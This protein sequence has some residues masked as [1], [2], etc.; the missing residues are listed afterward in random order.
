MQDIDL[1]LLPTLH[2][3]LTEQNVTR[4][5]ERVHLSV[6]ATSRALDRARRLFGDE[7]LVRRGRGV[8]RTPRADTLLPM[9][10]DAM[11]VLDALLAREP[12]FD[13][14][15]LRR[16]FVVRGNEAVIAALGGGIVE[17]VRAEAPHVHIRFE[18]ETVD[19]IEAVAAGAADLA[20][21]S[22]SDIPTEMTI[23][24][25]GAESIVGVI[26][27]DHP[28]V[29]RAPTIKAFAAL[30]HIVVSRRGRARGP[31]DVELESAGFGRTV[32]AVVP[33]Y[34]AAI[35]MVATSDAVTAAPSHFAAALCRG[36]GL[37]TF[38]L[39]VEV[40]AV[41]INQIWHGRFD[42]D[43]AHRWLRSCVARAA[44]TIS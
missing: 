25:L 12:H 3:L 17:F 41:R 40:P 35:A 13:A 7:L 24:H 9:L 20:V 44:E 10:A 19:D 37:R 26:R 4:A 11:L 27:E 6:P 42:G 18:N 5:A 29:R 31:I 2:V 21:G 43:P 22:Y 36:A 1:N 30:D 38:R 28:G 34:A 33:S 32:V 16:S 39:P 8:V 15:S 14:A 23:E